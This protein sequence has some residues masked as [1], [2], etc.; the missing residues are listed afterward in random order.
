[1]SNQEKYPN[2]RNLES[3]EDVFDDDLDV[4][5]YRKL[6]DSDAEQVK[7]PEQE[8][9]SEQEVQTE[10]DAETTVMERPQYDAYAASGRSKPQV[11]KPESEP[12]AQYEDQPTTVFEPTEPEP[13]TEFAEEPAPDFEPD[14][15]APV[16]AA[17]AYDDADQKTAVIAEPDPDFVE[18]NAEGVAVSDG[19]E[20]IDPRRGTT[21]LGLFL[22][23]LG[24]G[25]LLIM[26]GL[27]TL[28]GW[29]NSGGVSALEADFANSGFKLASVL[30]IAIPTVQLIAGVLLVLGLA[31]PLGAGLALALSAYLTMYEVAT[32]STGWNLLGADAAPVQLQL[33]LT[34][35]ALA[36]QFT[37][38]GRIGVDFS[39][40]WARRPLASSWIFCIL[41]VAAA[42]VLWYFTSGSWPFMR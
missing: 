14:P 1:M 34:A 33:L 6:A 20:E 19:E 25:A 40:G 37:G 31:T 2:D 26:H 30:G 17:P 21:S 28:F 8:V 32:S 23:R 4:P 22:L 41:G 29:A 36:I 13:A 42:I 27:T 15:V 3:V 38:P 7:E 16:M 18:D 9:Q 35:A 24:V 10:P 12:A 5:T 39:R 11:I